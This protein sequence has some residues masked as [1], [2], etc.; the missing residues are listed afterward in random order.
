MKIQVLGTGCP[1]CKKLG[2]NAEAAAKDLG[3]AYELEKVQEIDKILAFGVAA[4]P[5]L[6]VDG[7]VKFT[8]KLASVDEI[9]EALK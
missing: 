8:G 2:E 4:T 9:K 5:A 3:V 7:K 1:K 6:V